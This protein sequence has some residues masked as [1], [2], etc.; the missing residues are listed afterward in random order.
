[1]NRMKRLV[2]RT[3]QVK[4]SSKYIPMLYS[5]KDTVERIRT[6]LEKQGPPA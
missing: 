4:V 2:E 1:M 6:R 5:L 3:N